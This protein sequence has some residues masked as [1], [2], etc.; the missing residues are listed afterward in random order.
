L[1]SEENKSENMKAG[2]EVFR[3]KKCGY[4]TITNLQNKFKQTNSNSLQPDPTPQPETSSGL[5]GSSRMENTIS[6]PKKIHRCPHCNT[7]F[8]ELSPEADHAGKSFLYCFCLNYAGINAFP[9]YIIR[10]KCLMFQ[11]F[12][13]FR[14]TFFHLY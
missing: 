8:L 5:A 7:A 1:D 13:F 11:L 2:V 12:E 4:I 9:I 6:S 10:V 14:Q 3:C